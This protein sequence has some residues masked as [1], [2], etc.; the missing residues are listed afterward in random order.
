MTERF[1]SGLYHGVVTHARLRP[2]AHRLRYRIFM[3]LLDLDE[4]PR[5]DRSLRLFGHNRRGLIGFHD[6]DHLGGEGQLRA[7]VDAILARAD[8]DL[9]GGPV[10]LLCMPRVLGFVFNPI[11]VYF[12]HR[13]DGALA[14]MLY[15]VNNTFGD[16]HSYLI[17]VA[18]PDA[19]VIAQACDKALHV[20][21]F[22][23]MDMTY[24]F[25]VTPPDDEARLV[26]DGR[27]AQGPMITAA[28]RGRR[29]DLSDRAILKAFAAH[30]LLSVAVLAAIHWEAVKMLLK[31]L[32]LKP[33]ARA[34]EQPVSVAR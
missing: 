21:P 8:I 10:R 9:Q 17:P 5:L 28:F 19:A 2:R 27:D 16:R 31:G 23:D 18:D 15:E 6:K 32:K 29:E 20:S 34:P 12:C 22:M 11:S 24:R 14:A 1:A 3:T 13:R 26:V 4:L 7:E 33:G 30:P 25:E